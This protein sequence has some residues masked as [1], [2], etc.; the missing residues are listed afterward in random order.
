M[1]VE[2]VPLKEKRNQHDPVET[3]RLKSY[4]LQH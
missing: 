3:Y 2:V 4:L 1:F